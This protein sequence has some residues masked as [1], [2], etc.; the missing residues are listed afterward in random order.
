MTKQWTVTFN[1]FD[2]YYVRLGSYKSTPRTYPCS[3]RQQAQELADR[4]N[5]E[6]GR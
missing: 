6:Q 3:T 2:T 4:L 5:K 1:G